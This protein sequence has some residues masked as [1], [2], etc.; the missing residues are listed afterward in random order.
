MRRLLHG[1]AVRCTVPERCAS[2]GS[3]QPIEDRTY[4]GLRLAVVDQSTDVHQKNHQSA[5]GRSSQKG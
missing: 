4:L 5:I 1:S 2:H 3:A